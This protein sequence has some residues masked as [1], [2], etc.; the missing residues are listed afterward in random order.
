MGVVY[1]ASKAARVA[2]DFKRNYASTLYNLSAED[3]NILLRQLD[4]LDDVDRDR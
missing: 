1:P 2:A 4:V 3:I